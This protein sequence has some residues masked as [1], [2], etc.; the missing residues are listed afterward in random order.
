MDNWR[1]S[2]ALSWFSICIWKLKHWCQ[3]GKLPTGVNC[4]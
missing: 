1:R 4:S 2:D 3:P